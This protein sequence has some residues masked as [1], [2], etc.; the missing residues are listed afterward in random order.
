MHLVFKS[1]LLV[2]VPEKE[3]DDGLKGSASGCHVG[4]PNRVPGSWIQLD[5]GLTSKLT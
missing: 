2:N 3:A 1:L 4:D 5:P